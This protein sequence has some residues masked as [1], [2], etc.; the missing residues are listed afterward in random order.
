M[1]AATTAMFTAGP[2]NDAGGFEIWHI[3]SGA[4]P[5]RLSQIEV[6]Y[7]D[8]ETPVISVSLWNDY[9]Y[10][11]VVRLRNRRFTK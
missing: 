8:V 5:E 4:I 11:P 7:F 3:E 1:T 9:A 10:P 2:E 6:L